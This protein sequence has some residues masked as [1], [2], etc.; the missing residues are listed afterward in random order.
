M[1]GQS[2]SKRDET[3]T[4]RYVDRMKEVLAGS[5]EPSPG[6]ILEMANSVYPGATHDIIRAF[7]RGIAETVIISQ[8]VPIP[9]IKNLFVDYPHVQPLAEKLRNLAEAHDALAAI[10]AA[11]KTLK[12]KLSPEQG[13]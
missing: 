9:A 12:G 6:L 5:A 3:L 4:N 1:T 7:L 2:L 11:A 8:S 10:R 13:A